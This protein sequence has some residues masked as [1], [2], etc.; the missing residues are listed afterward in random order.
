MEQRDLVKRRRDLTDRR[1]VRVAL[2]PAGRQMVEG[3]AAERRERLA[4]LLDE[5][6]DDELDGFLRGARALRLARERLHS[7]LSES[8]TE[9]SR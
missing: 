9:A 3:V 6:T 5:L 4:R 8:S 7:P 2:T 1:V